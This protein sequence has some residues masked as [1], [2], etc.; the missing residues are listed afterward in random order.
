MTDPAF[1]NE[2]QTLFTPGVT[3][4][5]ELA[6]SLALPMQLLQNL[7]SLLLEDLIVLLKA[8]I[9]S[10]QSGSEMCNCLILP[11]QDVLKFSMD[12]VHFLD[13][14]ILVLIQLPFRRY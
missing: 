6:C 4:I 1:D 10:G 8:H 7:L 2:I 11:L 9:G 3:N 5:H 12:L 14:F 13:F